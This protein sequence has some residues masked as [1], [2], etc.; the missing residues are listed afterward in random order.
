MRNRTVLLATAA[1]SCAVAIGSDAAE[2]KRG[3]EVAV[4]DDLLFLHRGAAEGP[5]YSRDDAFERMRA[6]QGSVLR[7]NVVWAHAVANDQVRLAHRPSHVRYDWDSYESLVRL[8]SAYGVRVQFSLTGPAPAWGT[9]TGVVERGHNRPKARLYAQFVRAAARR[10]KGQVARYSV[11]NE[12]N[13]NS[14]LAPQRQAWWRYRRLYQLGYRAIKRVDPRAKVLFGELVA[15]NTKNSVAPLAFLRKVSCVDR[16]YHRVRGRHC[17][18]G[19]LKAD[20]FAH[21]PYEFGKP[22]ARARRRG[23]DDVSLGSL[24]RLTRALDRL[25][26]S[27]ALVPRHRAWL[28]LYLTEFGYFRAGPRRIPERR[29]ARWSVQGFELAQRNPRVKQLV[30]YVFV[31]PPGGTFFDLS[32][33][34]WDGGRTRTYRAL[35]RWARGAAASGRIRRPGRRHAGVSDD[36][37]APPPAEGPPD[38]V[39]AEQPS[40]EIIPGVPCPVEVPFLP[41]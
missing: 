38:N 30:Y 37:P 18:G 4:Q 2:A 27:R 21:H 10:F 32:L 31:R 20:G 24:G 12:P 26:R 7:V 41:G 28:P 39:A 13:W 23:R 25:K 35:V 15:Y 29:R 36:N 11:W 34:D 33:L 3:M 19:P 8:A 17:H 16:H 6:M 40:C 14:W 5:Y 1:L 9:P 22:P